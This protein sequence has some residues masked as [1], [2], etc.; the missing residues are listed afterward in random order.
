[1]TMPPISQPEPPPGIFSMPKDPDAPGGLIGA[2]KAALP[3]LSGILSIG[4]DIYSAQAN[5]AEAERNREFQERMSS[6]AVQRSVAD[7][8]AAGLNPALAYERSASSPSGAQAQIGN[9]IAAGTSTALQTKQI[10]N[11]IDIANAQNVADLGI[12]AEQ[13]KLIYAQALKTTAE[14]PAAEL[15]K[16]LSQ[17]QLEFLRAMQP[18]DLQQKQIEITLRRLGIPQAEYEAGI[19]GFKNRGIASAKSFSDFLSEAFTKKM[20]PGEITTGRHW[21]PDLTPGPLLDPNSTLRKTIR[22]LTP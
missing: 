7:Y 17:Q 13:R 16:D 20:G 15:T 1:M 19:A 2:A 3:W 22:R 14:T 8:K 5:R 21:Q 11:A 6:T 18:M 12:K 10:Q 4:G 9:P